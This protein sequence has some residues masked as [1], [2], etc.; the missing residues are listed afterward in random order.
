MFKDDIV[1]LLKNKNTVLFITAIIY[2][3][4]LFA[5]YQNCTIPVAIIVSIALISL[6]ITNIISWKQTLFWLFLFYFAIFN[7]N[8]KT[9]DTDYLSEISPQKTTIEGRILS[10]PNNTYANKSKFFFEVNK[11]H[12]NGEIKDNLKLKTLVTLN[13]DNLDTKPLKVEGTYKIKGLL[14]T[15]IKQGNPSQFDYG[16]YLRN[17]DVHTVFYGNFENCSE[18]NNELNF[19][20]NFIQKLNE[21]REDIIKTHSKYLKSPNLEVVG[22]IVFG[23]D[24][25][26]PPE[27]IKKSFINSGLLHILAASGMNV[28]FIFGFWFFLLT[29]FKVNYKIKVSTGILVVL[30]YAMMT[31]LGASVIRAT[32]MLVIILIGKL[33]DRDT[34]SVSLLGF[35][36]LLMLLIRPAFINDVGFQLSFVVTYGILVSMPAIEKHAKKIPNVIS[37][38]VFIPMIAQL[39]VIPIQMY[40]FNTISTYSV[41]ANILSSPILALISFGGFISSILA[42][43]KPISNF[44]CMIF[45]FALNPIVTFLLNISNYFSHLPNSLITT[46]HPSLFQVFMYYVILSLIIILL[47]TEKYRKQLIYS[48]STSILLLIITFIPIP[49]H[50]TEIIVFD[51]QN[52]DS[53]L[54]KTPGGKYIGIDTG[55]AGYHTSSQAK[56]VMLKYMKDRG[57]NNL[58]TLILTHFDN[59]HSG[60][61]VDY[62]KDLKIKNIYVN[63]LTNTSNT[64][65][66]IYTEASKHKNLNL[67]KVINNSIIYEEPN[68]KLTNFHANL[69]SSK[70][71]NENSIITMLESYNF[72]MLFMGDA[73]VKAFYSLQKHLNQDIDIL[74]V[75]HHGAYNVVDN[76]MLS[77]IKPEFAIISVGQNK[78]GHPNRATIETLK[79]TNILRTDEMNSI[80][81]IV[82]KNGEYKI[83]HFDRLKNKY[84]KI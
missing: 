14:K 45:D 18:I 84:V 26:A 2:I 55:K 23:D 65:N 67:E 36:A 10:I 54:I 25:V 68:I 48:L 66:D 69:P 63:S 51:V 6:F 32:I 15:P 17:Y 38:F 46:I 28:A 30:L 76:K 77:T 34:H 11:L 5:F 47:I 1:I 75:G 4:G 61:A 74:K 52:A 21:I 58:Y 3:I 53:F 29:R 56:A 12:I 37:G 24:A 42:I 62:I 16:K 73:G 8:L 72:K 31:G 41:F 50:N 49:N 81:I 82:Q 57:I 78:F 60:G 22:G 9:S 79:D 20:Q 19:T 43:I 83:Y 80:K 27:Y 39:W 64:A 40:Y 35:V 71:E 13:A 59:D 70:S 33:I 44:V 7:A